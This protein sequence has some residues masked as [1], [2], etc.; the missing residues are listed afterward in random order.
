MVCSLVIWLHGTTMFARSTA[1]A[2]ASGALVKIGDV[3]C[4]PGYVLNWPQDFLVVLFCFLSLSL[5]SWA[6]R[7]SS[8]LFELFCPM[9]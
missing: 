1:I 6:A 3:P 7:R 8:Q 9:F 4:L 5:R 2:S